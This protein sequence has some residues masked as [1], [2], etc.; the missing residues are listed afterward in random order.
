MVRLKAIEIAVLLTS[1]ILQVATF[2]APFLEILSYISEWCVFAFFIRSIPSLINRF[3]RKKIFDKKTELTSIAVISFF[4]LF[5][6]FALLSPR[7]FLPFIFKNP[8]SP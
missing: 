4:V 5:A 7:T 8:L 6:I 1:F 3:Y 2:F